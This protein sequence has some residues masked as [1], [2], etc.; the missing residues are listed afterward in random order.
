MSIWKNRTARFNK[1]RKVYIKKVYIKR[2]ESLYISV[3]YVK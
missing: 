2:K 3:F 1:K